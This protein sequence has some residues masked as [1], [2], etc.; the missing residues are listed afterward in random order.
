MLRWLRKLRTSRR[1]R[2]TIRVLTFL[3]LAN[4]V[5]VLCWLPSVYA[6]AEKDAQRVGLELLKQLGPIV[7][8]RPEAVTI[9]GQ[10]MFFSSKSTPLAVPEVVERLE[11]HCQSSTATLKREF[12]K[13]PA[14]AQANMPKLLR[15][16]SRWMLA[17][18]K[19]E[20]DKVGQVACLAREGDGGGIRAFL[21]RVA[22]FTEHGDVS[23]LGEMRYV[24]ARRPEGATSTLVLVMWT[25]GSFKLPAMFPK[26]GDAPGRDSHVVPRPPDSV[27]VLTAEVGAHPYALRMYDTERSHREVL[28]SYEQ[29]M[30]DRG[31]TRYELPKQH[32][33]LD[34]NQFVGA[35]AKDSGGVVVVVNDTPEGKTGVSLIELGGS[36][37]V[38]NAP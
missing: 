38:Y 28:A 14:A 21:D 1:V 32:A 25:E 24:V 6:D 8:E 29:V 19:T 2:G 20:D 11:R 5:L 23:K 35:Y 4:L 3:T 22:D 34:L 9:N 33:D 15:D 7:T 17:S 16:P 10:R 12:E 26:T 37:F 27:R 18:S 36:G 30:K 13:L 31:F